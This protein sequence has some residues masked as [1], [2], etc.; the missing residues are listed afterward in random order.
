MVYEVAIIGTGADPQQRDRDGYAMAY[1]H[2][3]GYQRLADC[4]LVAC[5]DIV[6][7][8]AEA[9]AENFDLDAVYTDHETLLAE[10]SLDIVSVCVPP[11]VHAEVVTDCAEMGDLAAVHCEKPMATTWG[12]CT[13]MVAACDANDVQIT[14]DHQRRFAKP[15]TEAK[16]L[17]DDGK[18]GD[19][20]R[21]EWS[22]VNLFDAG[23]HLFDLCTYF[24]DGETPEWALAGIDPDPD[25]RWFGARNEVQAVAQWG[26]ADGTQGVASTAE[27]DRQTVVDAYLR[28]VGEDGVIEIQP[29]D[30][31]PLR[32]R[33]DGGWQSVGTDGESV[34]GPGQTTLQI[35]KNKLAS[36]VPGLSADTDI[37]PSHYERAI[38]HLVA[39]LREGTE[40]RIS[41]RR[42]LQGTEL[43]YACWES[44]R[45][46]ERVALPLEIEDNPLEAICTEK[47]ETG[48]GPDRDAPQPETQE[49]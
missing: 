44:A 47:F 34:Y 6:P 36:A 14:I 1:R 22:E 46:G 41:G 15:V 20:R 3:P 19:L 9:F 42:A 30:G 40:P 10:Q 48:D 2:A 26:Y 7:E 5:A 43:I 4:E 39:S 37:G 49:L 23:T 17:L 27:G 45:R 8:N 11:T 31:P 29:D 38:E 18:I 25:N 24:T 32:V 35:A 16:R 33:T 21:L 13:A 28:L 12:D